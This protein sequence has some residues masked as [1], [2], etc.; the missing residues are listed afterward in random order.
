MLRLRSWRVALL[1]VAL[2]AAAACNGKRDSSPA[3]TGPTPPTAST[4][5]HYTAIGASDA[6]GVGASRLC[7][8]LTP[9][10]DGTGYV[11]ILARQLAAGRTFTLA[12]L[13]IPGA[14]LGPDT[15]ALA[16]RHGRDI[17]ANFIDA[18]LPLVAAETTLVTIF[19][20]G[21]DVNAIAAA[22][23][24][25]AAGTNLTGFVEDQ[26][27]Q[28]AAD[29]TR[30]VGGIRQRAPQARIVA[31]NLPN[32]ALL[33]YV[34]GQAPDRRRVVRAL[35]VGFSTQGVNPLT[36][37]GV[38]VVDILCEPRAYDTANVSSDGFHPND[39]GYGLMAELLTVGI[40]AT[41]PTPPP[42]SCSQMTQ[43]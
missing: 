43:F 4:R 29:L 38:F 2:A 30:L 28:F 25:G 9:C 23:S 17:P 21:N 18:E 12:N 19:A 32:L 1:V 22:A 39:R 34:S 33:P 31:L 11:P 37:Q 15:Q 35:A 40:N 16:R 36:G 20:G 26:V 7:I 27:R 5:V 6:V 24:A 10:P 41:S 13:G 3:P 42:T 14:V 8:P